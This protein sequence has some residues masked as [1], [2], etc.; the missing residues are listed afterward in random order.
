MRGFL[1]ALATGH[2]GGA[3]SLDLYAL[4]VG[5]RIVATY[6]GL[7]RG[8]NWHGLINSFNPAP[9]IARSS[10]AELLLRF[11]IRDLASRGIE[12]FDLGVGESRYKSAI[13]EETIELVDTIV[14][15]T[16]LGRMG[17]KVERARLATKRWVKRTPWA[18]SFVEQMRIG[19][20]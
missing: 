17:A 15:V 7:P 8:R 6:G 12:R 11:L 1:D 19:P 5:E 20:V 13:T 18:Q 9:E 2:G 4:S 10:P 14:P 3:P 16:A